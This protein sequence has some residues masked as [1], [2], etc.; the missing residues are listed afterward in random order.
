MAHLSHRSVFQTKWKKPTI[1]TLYLPLTFSCLWI[2]NFA[3]RYSFLLLANITILLWCKIISYR[4]YGLPAAVVYE[5]N[6]VCFYRSLKGYLAFILLCTKD[7]RQIFLF[8]W[9]KRAGNRIKVRGHVWEQ[10]TGYL[11]QCY[12]RCQR[13]PS[14]YWPSVDGRTPKAA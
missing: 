5:Y 9:N 14:G 13:V 3:L 1:I 10:Y 8:V 12:C 7:Q 2:R 4:V 11:L 6:R